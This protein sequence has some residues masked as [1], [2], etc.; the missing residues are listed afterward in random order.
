MLY[1]RRLLLLLSQSGFKQLLSASLLLIN[2]ISTYANFLSAFYFC[3]LF[4]DRKKTMESAHNKRR[5]LL[6]AV[7]NIYFSKVLLINCINI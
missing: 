6:V 2:I 3:L 7:L 5:R 4:V 1:G